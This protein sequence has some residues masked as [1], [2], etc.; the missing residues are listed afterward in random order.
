MLIF[1]FISS[2]MFFKCLQFVDSCKINSRI[3]HLQ[4]ILLVQLLLV[5]NVNTDD[6][7]QDSGMYFYCTFV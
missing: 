2:I 6:T 1:I 7:V 4:V 3:S 5:T